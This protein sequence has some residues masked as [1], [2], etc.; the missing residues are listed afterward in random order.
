MHVKDFEEWG[1][2]SWFVSVVEAIEL[3][4]GMLLLAPL[5]GFP[6]KTRFYGALLLGYRD[7]RRNSHPPEGRADEP[8]SSAAGFVLFSACWSPTLFGLLARQRRQALEARS[9]RLGVASSPHTH[10]R[11][12][13]HKNGA[14]KRLVCLTGAPRDLLERSDKFY[15]RSN[16]H[17]GPSQTDRLT[18]RNFLRAEHPPL[19]GD[20]S[21]LPFGRLRGGT[22]RSAFCIRA[23]TDCSE[24]CRH[25]SELPA[26]STR[27]ESRVEMVD[28]VGPRLTVWASGRGR[29]EKAATARRYFLSILSLSVLSLSILS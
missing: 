25:G 2:A 27:S 7:A 20:F 5:G 12:I 15:E 18:E 10:R 19:L 22:A 23:S 14:T 8:F 4:G 6:P 17:A 1:Y 16:F 13:D 9:C 21:T 28:G 24:A 29:S 26:G 11:A 3:V